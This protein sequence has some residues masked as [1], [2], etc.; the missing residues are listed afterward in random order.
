MREMGAI[1]CYLG[2]EIIKNWANRN[3]FIKQ[4]AFIDLMLKDLRLEKCKSTRVTIDS[5]TKMVENWYMGE[6]YKITKEEI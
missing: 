4:A 1:F 5:E 6:D 2:M 3:F